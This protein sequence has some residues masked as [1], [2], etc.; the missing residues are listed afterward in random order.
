[1]S[2]NIYKIKVPSWRATKD[3]SIKED[4]V[5]EIGRIN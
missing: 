2:G 3:I 1:M 5:E 4:I